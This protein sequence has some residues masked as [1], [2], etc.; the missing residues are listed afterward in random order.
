M[1]ITKDLF[2]NILAKYLEIDVNNLP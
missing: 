1:L 2:E